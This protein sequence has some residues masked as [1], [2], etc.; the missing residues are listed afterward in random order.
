[1]T[2]TTSSWDKALD[3]RRVT[4]WVVRI[5]TYLIY[6]YIIVVEIILLLGFILKLFGANPTSGFVDWVYHALDRVMAPFR[7]IFAPIELGTAGNDV[8]AVFDTSII[9]AMIVYGFVLLG[10]RLLLDWL[11]HRLAIIDARKAELDAENA[12]REAQ[13]RAEQARAAQEAAIAAAYAQASAPAAQPTPGT[14]APSA[15]VPPA[16]GS[17]VPPPPP[18][19]GT[20]PPSA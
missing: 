7:G 13:A 14:P 8:L 6:A 4:V 12:A 17:P 16:P 11:T 5:L 2:T 18:G 20:N 15:P 9:F 10:F 3:I 1:M 19:P